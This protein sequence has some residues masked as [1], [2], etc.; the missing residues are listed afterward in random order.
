MRRSL[1]I[2]S[3]IVRI[4]LY[5]RAAATMARAMPVLPLV[6]STSTLSLLMSPAFSAAAIMEKPIRSLTEWAGLKNSSL[7]TTSAFAP[8]VTR[9]KRTSGVLPISS[10]TSFAIVMLL[11]LVLLSFV[12]V[13]IKKRQ[14][15]MLDVPQLCKRGALSEKVGTDHNPSLLCL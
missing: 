5:P 11:L 13:E 15:A 1:L 14:S 9:F 10:V 3:G 12:D 4:S 7:A 2:V 8:S 6:G